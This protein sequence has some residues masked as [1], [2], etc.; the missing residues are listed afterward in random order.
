MSEH[1]QPAPRRPLAKRPAF[2]L[3]LVAVLLLGAVAIAV[4]VAIGS[5]TDASPSDA[6]SDSAAPTPPATDGAASVTATAEPPAAGAA[7]PA[8]CAD[9]YTR[10][11]APDLAPRVLNPAWTA[12]PGSD[13]K[14]YGSND[15]GLVTVLEATTK[16]ECNWVPETGAGHVFVITGV[17]Q[18]TPEQQASTLEYLAGTDLE[19]FEELEGVRCLVER[20]EG[21]E[22]YG[23]SHFL[24]EGI[25]IAT[26]WGGSGPDGYTHDIVA[27]IFG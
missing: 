14:G 23:E 2:W 16:L 1:T 8:D 9:I 20:S 11:W 15:A 18:L 12:N 22:N 10:D 3:A 26:R 21:G 25:W 7:I 6:Q 24:R 4:G 19:C 17:A 27:A 5:M 13:F